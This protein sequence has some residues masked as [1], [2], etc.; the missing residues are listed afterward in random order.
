MAADETAGSGGAA[1]RG[2]AGGGGAGEGGGSYPSASSAS[3]DRYQAFLKV[4]RENKARLKALSPQALETDT[5]ARLGGE[6]ETDS[7][8]KDH[9]AQ[10]LDLASP[11]GAATHP[12]GGGEAH[13]APTTD[14][15]LIE[16]TVLALSSKLNSLLSTRAASGGDDEAGTGDVEVSNTSAE[17][18]GA[19]PA[20]AGGAGPAEGDPHGAQS[21]SDEI[22]D[23]AQQGAQLN[24][25]RPRDARGGGVAGAEAGEG[26]GTQPRREGG[27]FDSTSATEDAAERVMV[28]RAA[29][30]LA[31]LPPACLLTRGDCHADTL[32]RCQVGEQLKTLQQQLDNLSGLQASN[33]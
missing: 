23:A 29:P 5:G 14:T 6:Y 4:H 15:S 11:N 26:D 3:N 10:I 19:G 31:I 30:L 12:P 20:D 1:R 9:M 33:P 25:D 27:S 16:S 32:P 24:G 7:K 18:G 22:G 17:A 13:A 8:V 28:R 2:A 21:R